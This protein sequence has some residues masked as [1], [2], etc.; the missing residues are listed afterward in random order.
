MPNSKQILLIEDNIHDQFF[1]KQALSEIEEVELFHIA[2]NGREALDKLKA[3]SML[4][5]LIF[6]DI[7]MPVMDGIEYLT[8][9]MKLPLIRDI[10]VVV[11]SSD[12][13]VVDSISQFGV[14]AFIEKPDNCI[15][16]KKLVDYALHMVFA[17][18]QNAATYQG[19]RLISPNAN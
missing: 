3:S 4:P 17:P 10:P 15:V 9:A 7:H 2:N 12:S 1:F 18:G 16:L 14:R 6:T 11:L 5:H 13:S 8:E 19:F